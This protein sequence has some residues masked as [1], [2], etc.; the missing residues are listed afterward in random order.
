MAQSPSHKFG[1]QLGK[2]LEDIVLYDILK[3]RLEQ[4]AQVKNYYLDWQR[5]RPARSG[6]KVTWEDKYGNKHDLD[7]VIEV[8]GTDKKLGR[9]VAFIESAWRR[10]TKHSKNKAQEIQGAILPIIELHHLSAPFYGVVLAG[11]FT[12]PAL[13]Q[14][15][16]NGF[17]VIYIPYK[18]V[19]SAFK[20]IDFDVAF[21]EDTPDESYT[22]AFRQLDS[23]TSSDK[24]KLRQALI[25][26]CQEEVDRFMETLRNCLER[27]ISNIVLIPLF[28]KRY[29]FDSIDD[30]ISGLDTLKID[31]PV[32]EFEKFEV[33]VDYNNSDTIRATFQNKNL[34]TDFLRKLEH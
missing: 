19:V 11:D 3:P 7:F 28:G 30:A 9:P 29:E 33:I 31:S 8:D 24:E 10:Y 32:G 4:F 13:E 18:G 20:V 23:L 14:L 26:V 15:K 22:T 21:D 1:Q 12:K 27:Y 16:N 5:S 25:R 34:L 17:A 6:K 2:L